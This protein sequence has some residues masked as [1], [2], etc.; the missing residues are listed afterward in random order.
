[1]SYKI[2]KAVQTCL[3]YPSQWDAWTDSGQYLYLRYR[4]GCGTVEEFDDPD[5]KTWQ[6]K[7]PNVIF[8][9][10]ADVDRGVITLVEFAK[11]AG[12]TLTLGEGVQ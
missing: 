1:M 2:V 5:P 8:E 3:G 11:C 7:P 9:T 6:M 10:T 4:Y 12:L